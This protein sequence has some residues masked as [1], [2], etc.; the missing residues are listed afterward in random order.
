MMHAHISVIPEPQPYQEGFAEDDTG[1]STEWSALNMT[2]YP[3]PM[4]R[5]KDRDQQPEMQ[6]QSAHFG[7]NDMD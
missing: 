5:P 7:R 2:V 1:E 4:I 6:Y 3:H